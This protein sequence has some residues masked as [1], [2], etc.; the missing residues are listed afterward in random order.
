MTE[1]DTETDTVHMS[2]LPAAL[3]TGIA[4]KSARIVVGL[5]WTLV[6]GPNGTGL[7]HTPQRGTAGCRSLPEPGSYAGRGLAEL[8][9]LVHAENVFEQAIGFAAINAHHNRC[10]LKGASKNGLDLVEE[11]GE[12]TVVIG[13]FPGL[14]ERLPGAAVIER[15]PGP[16]DYPESAADEL[17]PKAEHLVITASALVNG[18]LPRLLSLAPRAF[19]VLLGPSTPLASALFGFGIDALSGLVVADVDAAF[20][21]AGEG[22]AVSALKRHGR[23]VTLLRPRSK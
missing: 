21:A 4:G 23:Y 20:H 7:A 5:N 10:D 22:G 17:L 12:R 8:A 18:T 15:E 6:E 14:D 3:C 16:G 13:R 11:R 2:D 9:S 1:T 19:T